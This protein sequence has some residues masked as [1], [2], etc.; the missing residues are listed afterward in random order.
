MQHRVKSSLEFSR[1]HS[2]LS[3]TDT[4]AV[5]IQHCS[6]RFDALRIGEDVDA[7]LLG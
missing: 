4:V 3:V 2:D 7:G 6:L 1:Q 5:L